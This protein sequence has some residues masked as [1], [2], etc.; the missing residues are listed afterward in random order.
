RS[1]TRPTLWL[2][3]PEGNGRLA[4]AQSRGL[5]GRDRTVL[6]LPP[7]LRSSIFQRRSRPAYPFAVS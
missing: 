6:A 4:A 3:D 5:A 1:I 7:L 2:S